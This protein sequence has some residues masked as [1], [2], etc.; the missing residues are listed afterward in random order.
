MRTVFLYFI[1]ESLLKIWKIFLFHRKYSSRYRQDVQILVIFL[2]P[3]QR[4]TILRGCLKCNN[5]DVM[6]WLA[7]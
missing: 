4:F 2:Y 5:Y 3:V 6:K 7:Q 1:R